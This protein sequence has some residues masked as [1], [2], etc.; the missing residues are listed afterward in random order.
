MSELIFEIITLGIAIA[1]Q[2]T[3]GTKVLD[4]PEALIAITQ[5]ANAAYQAEVG[6]PIDPEKIKPIRPI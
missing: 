6:M 3:G 4:I 1:R 5:K 2:Q